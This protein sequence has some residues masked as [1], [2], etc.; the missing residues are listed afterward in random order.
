[1]YNP[2][3]VGPSRT[4]QEQVANQLTDKPFHVVE[5]GAAEDAVQL[6]S[7]GAAVPIGVVCEVPKSE[8][9][10]PA[11][12]VI[13]IARIGADTDAGA[14]VQVTTIQRQGHGEGIQHFGSD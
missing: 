1:M 8:P 12:A 3:P 6:F 11:V 4:Y 2:V 10:S 13:A 5:L 14:D 7:A 9:D